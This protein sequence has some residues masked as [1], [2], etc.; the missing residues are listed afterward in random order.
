MPKDNVQQKIIDAAMNIVA[1]KKISGTRMHLIAKEAGIVQSNVHYYF[2]TKNDLLIALLDELQARFSEKRMRTI[3]LENK[4]YTENLHGLFEEKKDDI[5]NHK[6]IDYVQFD[7]WVQG[8][9]DPEIRSKFQDSFEVWRSGINAVLRNNEL[10][11]GKESD[12]A[13]TLPYLVLSLMIGASMQYLIHEGSFDLDQYFA[14]AEKMVLKL[15][16]MPE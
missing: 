10:L 16:D 5:V 15:L 13:E 6:E 9:V 7:Y 2:P 1:S 11:Q 3:D 12:L 14:T 8:T 4:N